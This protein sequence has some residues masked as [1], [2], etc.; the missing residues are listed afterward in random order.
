[1]KRACL[2]QSIIVLLILGVCIFFSCSRA[3]PTSETSAEQESA[4]PAVSGKLDDRPVIVAFGD[5]LTS[6][7]GVDPGQNYPAKLQKRLDAEGYLYRV[8][9][10][11]VSGDTTD[12]GLNRLQSVIDLHP[13]IAIVELGANDGLRGLP[14]EV[15]RQNLATMVQQ[16][17][18]AGAKVV[19]AGMQV[20]PNYG[21]LYA[22]AFRNIFKDI[23]KQYRVPLIPFFLEGVGGNA[24]LNQDDGIH[25]TV[26]GYE[27]VVKNIWKVLQPLL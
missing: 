10:A 5:S 18:S 9:N 27:V 14:A 2:N 7:L 24:A 11:G 12:Q 6:G 8:V 21:P 19:L 16:L 23:A 15:T 26:D 3:K 22:S 17:Q 25:P 20:P 4:S 13:A 1:M